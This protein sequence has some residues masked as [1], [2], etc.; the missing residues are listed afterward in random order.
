MQRRL[1]AELAPSVPDRPCRQGPG[2]QCIPDE[3]AEILAGDRFRTELVAAE[4]APVVVGPQPLVEQLRGALIEQPW[5][6]NQNRHDSNKCD[7]QGGDVA[8]RAPGRKHGGQDETEKAE[9]PGCQKS[10]G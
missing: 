10:L 9:A 4:K 1:S 5:P 3:N 6:Y 7:C 8:A 2:G